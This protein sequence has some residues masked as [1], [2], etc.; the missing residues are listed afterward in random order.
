MQT[1]PDHDREERIDRAVAVYLRERQSP[2]FELMDWLKAHADLQPE[3][4]EFLQDQ[5]KFVTRLGEVLSDVP[6]QADPFVPGQIVGDIQIIRLLKTGGMGRVFEA[7]QLSLKRAVAVKTLRIR[8]GFRVSMDDFREEGVKLAELQHPNILPVHTSGQID[9]WPYL[10]LE[11]LPGNLREHLRQGLLTTTSAIN[12]VLSVARAVEHAAACGFLHLDIKPSNVL[13]D[14]NRQ[15]KLCDFGLSLRLHQRDQR[16]RAVAGTAEYMAPEQFRGQSEQLSE[17]TDVYG[18]GTLLYEG[19]SGQPP[20]PSTATMWQPPVP[21]QR[22]NRTVPQGL[23]AITHRCLME[24]PNDRFASAGELAKALQ[25]LLRQPTRRALLATGAVAVGLAAGGGWLWIRQQE[26]QSREDQLQQHLD[27]LRESDRRRVQQ[28]MATEV[29]DDRY[30]ELLVLPRYVGMFP[31]NKR[32][33][34]YQCGQSNPFG[35]PP[36]YYIEFNSDVPRNRSETAELKGFEAPDNWKIELVMAV[37]HFN[38]KS[39]NE[40]IAGGYLCF[41]PTDDGKKVQVQASGV[42]RDIAPFTI[43]LMIF[44]RQL[45]KS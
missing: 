40:L 44:Y 10:V 38:P 32:T 28:A 45:K 34:G 42:N 2:Q 12:L 23:V 36:T 16:G 39:L 18:L 30:T 37:P 17:R 43:R 3:L 1:E 19:L 4:S 21:L 41:L 25:D 22:W 27:D 20:L 33:H 26:R 9:G 11:L 24:D 29:S 7:W 8:E 31:D 5:S 13:M 15:P 6:K 14:A 35:I